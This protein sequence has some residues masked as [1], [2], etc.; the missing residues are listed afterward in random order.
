MA[1]TDT[2]IKKAK[3][4]EKPYK[5][6]DEKG[7]FIS[8]QPRSGKWWRFKYRFD[9]KEKLLS[10]GTYPEVSLKKARKRRDTAREEIADGIDP[11]AK[12]KA[13]KVAKAGAESFE[14]VAR[15][16]FDKFSPGWAESHS[17]NVI[18]RL[19]KCAFPW[20]GKS[21]INEITAPELLRVLRRIENRGA[22]E[23]AHRIRQ[24]CGQIF[25]YAIATGRA[26]RDISHDLR[27]A[28]PPPVT[29]HFASITEPKAIGQ[30]LRAIDGYEG[31]P[32]TR[33]ALQLA[34]FVFVRP[35]ELRRAEWQEI[36][37]K[38][39]EWK[40]P[41]DKMKMKQPHVVPLSK[42]ALAILEEVQPLTG[43]GKYVFPSIRTNSRPMS[44]NTVN[45][46]LRRLGYTGKEMTG[47]GFRSMASTILNEQGF[48]R[49]WIERQLAH[50][51]GNSVRAAYNYAEHLPKRR[52]MMQHWSDYLDGLKS[53]A[54]V[55]S[56]NK[57]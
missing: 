44:E 7:L 11:S 21:S 55:V 34:P 28:I 30:L 16:W 50:T 47:H 33:C 9:G 6:S 42:Q 23:T 24:Y 18:G 41:A 49:D 52:K 10:L 26:D 12:R 14:A 40:I 25:R 45:A 43:S 1:L 54:E 51:E 3:T 46:A 19:E 29:E 22:I 15:E 13:E 32:S 5:L 38:A 27:G 53:G 8:I 4:K 31:S 17:S 56:I 36:D 20:L 35:G 48:N 39:A 2:A 37:L 57:A